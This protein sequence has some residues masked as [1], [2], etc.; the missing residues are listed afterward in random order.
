M[1]G[2]GP[3]YE[4]AWRS[5]PAPDA[6]V[7]APRRDRIERVVARRIRG[8]TVVLEH[9]EDTFN[10]GAVLRTCEAM[11]LQ[12]VHV[13][14]DPAVPFRANP[15]VTQGCE[16]WLDIHVH[17]DVASCLEGLRREGYR[18]LGS[19]L[20]DDAA[21]LFTLQFDLPM[22]LVFGN[23]RRGVS[24][25]ALARC[26]GTFWVPM[27]GF[28]QSLNVS[29]AVS[30]CVTAA[31]GW[32]TANRGSDGDLD[33]EARSTLTEHFLRLS[34]KQ[35]ARIYGAGGPSEPTET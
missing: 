7:L 14:E 27:R 26:D 29:A 31:V 13:I 34:V 19:A 17:R 9:L 10:M 11:G 15:K 35:R 25:E 24:D 2:G 12:H 20:R 8:V 33:P 28:S 21:S 5:P 30:A 18:V 1:K 23:E 16:K 32:W 4:E 3:R 22:A 6:L